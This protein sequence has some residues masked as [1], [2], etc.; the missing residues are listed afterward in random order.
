MGG[1]ASRTFIYDLNGNMTNDG[2]GK[3]YAWDAANR[4]VKITYANGEKTEFSYDGLGRRVKIVEKDA[5]NSVIGDRRFVWDGLQ[6]VEER[7]SSNVLVKRYYGQGFVTGSS[8]TPAAGDKHYYSKDHLGS[9]RE[10]TDSTGVVDARIDY[11]SYGRQ[12]ALPS[13][14]SPALWLRADSLSQSSGS[15]VSGWNDESGQGKNATQ[16]T[17][18]NQP[19]FQANAINGKPAVRF[20][21]TDDFL[22]MTSGFADFTQGMTVFVVAKPT[23]VKA[24]A[25]LFDF[26]NGMASSNVLMFRSASTDS[27]SFHSYTGGSLSTNLTA[28]GMLDL[29]QSHVF[30][31][32]QS[33][34]TGKI[35]KDGRV[36]Q[37]GTAAAIQNTSRGNNYLAKSNWT[38]DEY[39]Q[40]DISEVVIFNRALTE[41]ERAQVERYLE[42]KYSLG[43]RPDFRYTGHF[44]H[45]KSGLSLAQVYN[46]TNSNESA[47]MRHKCY[48]KNGI[49]PA[50]RDSGPGRNA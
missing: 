38:G 16:G 43:T 13:S 35:Y 12:N 15:P 25:R 45:E 28:T 37:T 4:L 5:S 7:D 32:H 21:G 42:D 34:T 1:A 30:G 14:L 27:L 3:V 40:G 41:S 47:K 22:S 17:S 6:I 9:I 8:A 23:A 10:V 29:N 50:S 33:G 46:P 18:G 11:D 24:Y 44:Y 39:F 36:V 19:T 2:A 26:G 20:D 49:V 31:Y 48:S